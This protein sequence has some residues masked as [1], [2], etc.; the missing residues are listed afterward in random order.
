VQLLGDVDQLGAVV[1]RATAAVHSSSV[2]W[3]AGIRT[4]KQWLIHA[5]GLSLREPLGS[6]R[7]PTDD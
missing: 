7:P 4:T 2:L 1:T 6:P 3:G 5:V